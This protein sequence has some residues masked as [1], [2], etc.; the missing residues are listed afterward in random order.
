MKTERLFDE[1]AYLR[2]FEAQVVERRGIQGKQ[3][4]ILDRTLFYPTSGGQPHDEGVLDSMRVIDVYEDGETIV[5][6]LEGMIGDVDRIRGEIDW[7][8][9]FDHMQQHTGQHILSQAFV[10]S[11]GAETVGFHLGIESS[12]I[13]LDVA[14]LSPDDFIKTESMANGIVFENREVIIRQVPSDKLHTVPLRKRPREEGRIRVVEVEEF[15]WSACCGTHVRRTGDVG[16]LKIVRWERYKGGTR[17][18]FLCGW[19]AL[20]DYEKKTDILKEVCRVMTVGQEDVLTTL[21]RWKEEKHEAI[22]KVRSM[23]DVVLESEAKNLV[24]KAE[25]VGPY[26]MVLVLFENRD[27]EEVQ[28]LVKKLSKADGVVALVGLKSGRGYLYLGRSPSVEIDARSLVME[29]CREMDGK[30]GGSPIMAQGS[31]REASRVEEA[32]E[33]AKNLVLQAVS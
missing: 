27:S 19:R 23:L 17:V 21:F 9:R 10:R 30:G 4:V 14:I 12:T 2:Q 7:S 29:A 5:H 13:D 6:V 20:E 24:D 11:V 28:N 18:T 22:K 25:L 31:F 16:L 26:K 8:R 3:G 15:D 32:L 33:K 1:D